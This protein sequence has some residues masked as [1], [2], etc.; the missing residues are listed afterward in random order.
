MAGQT[1]VLA[2]RYGRTPGK[3][4]RDRLLLI[5]AAIVFAIVLGAWIVWAGLDGQRPTVEATDTG[6]RLL[7]EQRAVE[8]SWTLSVPPGN[9]TACIVQALND[10]FTVVGWKVVELPA[11]DRYLRTFTEQVRTAQEANT[12]LIYRCW[13]T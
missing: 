3:R 2:A 13:L 11:S 4:T 1:E 7:T 9:E 6:H 12:G 8:V 5:G 10:D